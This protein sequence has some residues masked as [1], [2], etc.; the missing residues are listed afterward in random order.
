MT[1]C[2]LLRCRRRVKVDEFHARAALRGPKNWKVLADAFDVKCHNHRWPWK[3]GRKPADRDV[4]IPLALI[5]GMAL[6]LP[7]AWH[8]WQAGS[9]PRYVWQ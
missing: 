6:W 2:G 5:S 1:D 3:P 8:R 4:A 7:P 9:G